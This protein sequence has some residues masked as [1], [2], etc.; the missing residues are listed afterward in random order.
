M[1]APPV[2]KRRVC[3]AWSGCGRRLAVSSGGEIRVYHCNRGSGQERGYAESSRCPRPHETPQNQDQSSSKIHAI[4]SDSRTRDERQAQEAVAVEA[5]DS[6]T[7]RGPLAG[8]E[9]SAVDVTGSFRTVLVV[10][11]ALQ[12]DRATSSPGSSP[13]SAS[14]F[15][16][17]P[18]WP[19]WPT[20]CWPGDN[21]GTMGPTSDA[22]PVSRT[23]RRTRAQ[24]Y[25]NRHMKSSS[26]SA[27]RLI[28]DMRSMCPAGPLAFFGVT[29]C[30]LGLEA[31]LGGGSGN[32]ELVTGEYTPLETV[33][34]DST[35]RA[36]PTSA[37]YAD[38]G[39]GTG[40][41]VLD[42]GGS[43]SSATTPATARWQTSARNEGG[44]SGGGGGGG[45][46]HVLPG[47]NW[48]AGSIRLQSMDFKT[49]HSAS[50]ALRSDSVVAATRQTLTTSPSPSLSISHFAPTQAPEIVDLRGK[51]GKWPGS[52]GSNA[53]STHPLF[54]LSLGTGM[55]TTPL[56]LS[57]IGGG[58]R[59]NPA[60]VSTTTTAAVASDARRNFDR[61]AAAATETGSGR[62]LLLLVTSAAA[63]GA[64]YGK[65]LEG[66]GGRE[67]RGEGVKVQ[68]LAS[69]PPA[70]SSPDLLAA[71]HDGQFVAVGSHAL[72]L[73]ACYRLSSHSA[74]IEPVPASDYHS[75]ISNAG[76]RVPSANELLALG[77]R[78]SGLPGCCASARARRG[79]HGKV[80]R[81]GHQRR[82]LQNRRRGRGRRSKRQAV[83]LCTLR[84]PPGYRAKGLAFVDPV[85]PERQMMVLV[86][87]ACPVSSSVPDTNTAAW[88]KS[89][90]PT[91]SELPGAPRWRQRRSSRV[92][93]SFCTVLLRFL[94]PMEA[95][96]KGKKAM[97]GSPPSRSGTKPPLAFVGTD[98]LPPPPGGKMRGIGNRGMRGHH[99]G[100]FE[101]SPFFTPAEP[102]NVTDEVA[103]RETKN[104]QPEQFA[105]SSF[106][107]PAEPLAVVHEDLTRGTLGH[108]PGLVGPNPFLTPADLLALDVPAVNAPG[109]VRGEGDAELEHG[110]L[111]ASPEETTRRGGRNNHT[112]REEGMFTIVPPLEK[113]RTQA[114][115]AAATTYSGSQRGKEED[116]LRQVCEQLGPS[117]E[118]LTSLSR[119][120]QDT[121]KAHP[122]SSLSSTCHDGGIFLARGQ[123]RAGDADR[124]EPVVDSGFG[125]RN[126]AL[127]LDA[128]ARVE[129]GIGERLE[130]MERVLV[131]LSDR[132]GS[133]ERSLAD[134]GVH[135][136]DS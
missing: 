41:V 82:R 129:K 33:P 11:A 114:A 81:G 50:S 108:Q 128:L 7:A 72:G 104:H 35:A 102:L 87:A 117:T 2:A 19:T 53:D 57:S 20:S 112:F 64:A 27:T 24:L 60:S 26:L 75:R 22:H 51:L 3:G 105:R 136:V 99:L 98:T 12:E 40:S 29:D 121:I 65:S 90:F 125:K 13:R 77:A 80:D 133:L 74:T 126:E 123:Q 9:S 111:H 67:G 5:G 15:P 122:D 101:P 73:V 45:F 71:S 32:Q 16:P 94:L 89:A 124:V 63:Q 106:L 46:Q 86:L 36:S 43:G 132:V 93:S 54:R 96:R 100:L 92:D 37:A 131:G 14:S 134:R 34:G 56:P 4:A 49:E 39:T 115:N 42:A 68:T 83:P 135:A 109:D 47:E 28:G 88:T 107:S 119:A 130:R 79:G 25:R 23:T 55:N 61:S 110:S 69:L 70:L 120:P 1:Y 6:P 44:D 38:A 97:S 84:L 113:G 103:S 8:G 118:W 30:G 48:L 17:P 78:A 127:F 52:I 85:V 18:Q 116:S 31:F 21:G 76:A 59:M 91:A 62:P 10:E 58:S 95:N 66:G